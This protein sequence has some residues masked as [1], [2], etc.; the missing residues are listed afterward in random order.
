VRDEGARRGGGSGSGIEGR[1][2]RLLKGDGDGVCVVVVAMVQ[3]N[4]CNAMQRSFRK[5]S[6]NKGE[7]EAMIVAVPLFC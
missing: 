6:V 7:R 1:D 2:G 5:E 4:H 3:C